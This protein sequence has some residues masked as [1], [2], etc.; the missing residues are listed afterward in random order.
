MD[1]DINP[2]TAYIAQSNV[3]VERFY[4][5]ILLI[6]RAIVVGAR[7]PGKFWRYAVGHITKKKNMVPAQLQRIFHTFGCIVKSRETYC[8]FGPFLPDAVLPGDKEV[9]AIHTAPSRWDLL[10]SG[11]RLCQFWIKRRWNNSNQAHQGDQRLLSWYGTIRSWF[12]KSERG[13][14]CRHIG[15]NSEDYIGRPSFGSTL[16][17]S[18]L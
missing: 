16:W 7:L 5:I 8:I 13:G 6:V 14:I 4:I 15:V 2:T 18:G 12:H 3:S 10:K 11:C 1:V 9:V 17:W